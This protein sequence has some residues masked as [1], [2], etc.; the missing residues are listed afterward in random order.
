VIE[1]D[2]RRTMKI[3]VNF[4]R[5][6]NTKMKKIQWIEVLHHSNYLVNSEKVSRE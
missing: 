1:R 5:L 6:T 2:V 4:V 3:V